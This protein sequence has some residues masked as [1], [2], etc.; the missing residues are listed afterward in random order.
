MLPRPQDLYCTDLPTRPRP[1]I[2]RIL[3]AGA[4]GYVGGRLVPDLLSRGCS[5][6]VMVRNRVFDTNKWPNTEVVVADALK[7]DQLNIALKGVQV[8]YYLIH[9]LSLGPDE[10][11]DA[12][13]VAAKNF[14]KAANNKGVKRIIYLGGAG[15]NRAVA[16]STCVTAWQFSK[17]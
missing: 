9:S 3:V 17:F 15:M 6:R 12:D 7:E 13:L 5:L 2:G 14:Q 1:S 8:A 10:F 4:T 16:R 11:A